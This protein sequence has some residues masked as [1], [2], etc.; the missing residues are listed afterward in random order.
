MGIEWESSGTIVGLEQDLC[1][2]RV[3][4]EWDPIVHCVNPGTPKVGLKWE[5]RLTL[6]WKTRVGD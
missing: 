1:E 3:G 6:E 2:P 4:L 5:T